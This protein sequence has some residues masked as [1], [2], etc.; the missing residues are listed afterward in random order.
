MSG[1]IEWFDFSPVLDCTC[2]GGRRQATLQWFPQYS[3]IS[4]ISGFYFRNILMSEGVHMCVWLGVAE[5]REG[6]GLR[7]KR[8]FSFPWTALP[9]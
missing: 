1:D 2:Q 8:L 7:A 5:E 9:C 3:L 6:A 4:H